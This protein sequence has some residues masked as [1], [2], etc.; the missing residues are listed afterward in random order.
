MAKTAQTKPDSTQPAATSGPSMEEMNAIVA[1]FQQAD[2]PGLETSAGAM[3][4]Q[5]PLHGFGWKSLG[6]A[7]KMQRRDDEALQVMQKA[8]DLVPDDPDVHNNLGSAL[9]ES[10]QR[11]L[12]IVHFEKALALNPDFPDALNGLAITLK[13][14]GDTERVI[15]LLQRAIELRPTFPE[16]HYNLG[17]AIK[18][19][20]DL[21]AAVK[22]YMEALKLRPGYADAYNSLG[23]TLMLKGEPEEALACYQKSLTSNP[24]F[25]EALNGTGNALRALG[26][27]DEAIVK[28]KEALSLKPDHEGFHHNLAIAYSEK[29]QIDAALASYRESLRY[30]PDY[31]SSRAGLGMLLIANGQ[32]EEG[33]PFYESRWEGFQQAMEGLLKRPETTL[34][35]WKGEPVA[36]SDALLLFCEQGLG[37]SLQFIRYVPLLAARFARIT[38]VCPTL[39]LNIFRGSFQFKHVEF[40][41]VHPKDQSTWHWHCTTMSVPLAMHTTLQNLPAKVPYLLAPTNRVDHWRDRLQQVDGGKKPRVGLVWAGGNLL[42]DDKKRS[43]PPEQFLPLTAHH[44]MT[45]ISLQKANDDKK[46]ARDHHKTGLIDWM[47]DIQDFADTAALIENLDLVITVDTAVAHLAGALGKPVWMMNRHAGDF[48]WMFHRQDTPW[49]PTMRLFRQPE[50]GDWTS[51]LAQVQLALEA[52]RPDSRKTPTTSPEPTLQDDMQ[53]LFDCFTQNA[54]DYQ[55]RR[56]QLFAHYRNAKNMDLSQHYVELLNQFGYTFFKNG[57]LPQACKFWRE[58]LALQPDHHYALHHLGVALAELNQHE[59]AIALFRRAIAVQP[60]RYYSH[61]TLAASLLNLGQW[62]EGWRYY[63]YRWQGSDHAHSKH[64]KLTSLPDALSKSLK[65]WRGEQP[66]AGDAL[67]LYAEQGYGD[68]IQFMRLLPQ[69]AE[70]FRQVDFYC[71]PALRTLFAHN[72]ARLKNVQLIDDIPK[73]VSAW[74]WHSPLLSLPLA[75]GLRPD[76]IPPAPYLKSLPQGRKQ[77][78]HQLTSQLDGKPLIGIAWTGSATLSADAQRSIDPLLLIGLL[79]D[80]RFHWLN[81]QKSSNGSSGL[82]PALAPWLIDHMPAIEDFADTAALIEQLD[83]VITVDTS[84]AH[85]AG[86]MGKPVWL[87]NRSSPDWR[88]MGQQEKTPWYGSMRIFN[89]RTRDRW[90]EVVTELAQAL[91]TWHESQGLLMS[92]P[93][94]PTTVM[95]ASPVRPASHAGEPSDPAQ[96]LIA[97]FS[98]GDLPHL[99]QAA[100]SLS[101]DPISKNVPYTELG[102]FLHAVA[103]CLQQKTP[104]AAGLPDLPVQ[105]QR[106]PADV[107][108]ALSAIHEATSLFL[109]SLAAKQD[110]VLA[111]HK[112]AALLLTHNYSEAAASYYGKVLELRPHFVE[113]L[114]NAGTA[115]MRLGELDKAVSHYQQALQQQPQ[116]VLA[117]NG[118]AVTFKHQGRFDEAIALF[119]AALKLQPGNAELLNNLGATLL[120]MHQVSEAINLFRRS[121]AADPNYH[122]AHMGLALA[123]L[124]D[125]QWAE[126]WRHYEQRWFGSNFAL[127]GLV[128]KSTTQLPNWQGQT[129]DPASNKL[130]VFCEQG[131]GDNLQFARYIPLAAEKFAKVT[132]FCHAPLFNIFTGSFCQLKNVEVIK[133]LPNDHSAWD[134]HCYIMSLP[135]A[136]G[137]TPDNLPNQTP[138]LRS[139]G[140]RVSYWGQRLQEVAGD[141]PRV[142]LVWAGGRRLRDD[143]QRSIALAQFAALLQMDG[144]A[145]VSLQKDPPADTTES[146]ALTSRL[147]DW[148]P[149]IIDFADTAALIDTLDLVISV[150]TSVAHLAGALGKP[151]WL[152]NRYSGDWRWMIERE[153]SPWYPSMR[154]F[155]QPQRDDWGNVLIRVEEALHTWQQAAN[156]P[157]NRLPDA[158]HHA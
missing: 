18:A 100:W 106:L 143:R 129:V 2:W 128:Q 133:A 85:L 99:E 114:T 74:Q 88:W 4:R 30:N 47:N 68:Q 10:G 45:W 152:L 156:F 38:V 40:T 97:L 121:I 25:H 154:I 103:L 80:R 118:L 79:T 155:N 56:D 94:L 150:D 28:Y 35:Q 141:K 126:G 111:L 48:R 78:R 69:V 98:S 71:S 86:A 139:P 135:L 144:V 11:A 82:P 55:T 147:I 53:A 20:G 122:P 110:D 108:K 120:D 64:K 73:D 134:Y 17:N 77:W 75:L 46:K 125:G 89:Q 157:V 8:A 92:E 52:W 83:L 117:M 7:L 112:L 6:V 72:L 115:C 81:L 76:N 27:L 49:Y 109:Q 146:R 137:T 50:P 105:L 153:D 42:R 33:W 123:L 37:D 131:L 24:Q 107:A 5:W 101:Q 13:Q 51:V 138:Y 102:S 119:Q 136:F 132:L 65:P 113:A 145:W 91:D 104:F 96:R 14:Q 148:M 21:D 66:P 124:F 41:D 151:V 63:E 87:L 3:T 142:G 31:A 15:A 36:A 12:A 93:G 149:E 23:N 39:L 116:Y 95:A 140:N 19:Q 22:S 34:P 9:R 16:A 43:I 62:D 54:P 1:L 158:L 44:E 32:M 67:L 26:R 90:Q 58:S 29:L 130:L 60:E 61:Y 84:I 127:Q 59:E 57:N 70:R